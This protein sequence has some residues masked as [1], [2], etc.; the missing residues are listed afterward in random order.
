MTKVEEMIRKSV[1]DTKW[2]PRD[3]MGNVLRKDDVVCVVPA[4]PMFGRVTDVKVGGIRT[5][6][7]DTPTMTR[8]VIVLDIP[9]QPGFPLRQVVKTVNPVSE[10][11][12]NH[13]MEQTEQ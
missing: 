8:I 11:I 13:A 10:L 6:Q 7:G 12:V 5:P 3:S 4:G 9:S 2:E 1:Q